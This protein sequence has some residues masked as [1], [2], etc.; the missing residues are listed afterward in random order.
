MIRLRDNRGRVREVTSAEAVEYVNDAKEL[1]MVILQDGEGSTQ[2]L[3]PGDRLFN[4]YCN[5]HKMRPATTRKVT[6]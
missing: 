4:A 1:A 3:S 5:A 2:L 6:L